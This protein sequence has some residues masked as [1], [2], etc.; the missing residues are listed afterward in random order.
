MALKI[1]KENFKEE[2]LNE[3][4]PVLVDFWAEW[5]S[6]CLMLAPIIDEISEEDNGIKV[7]KINV[8]EEMELALKFS[9]ESIPML[10]LFKD[11]KPIGK[12]VGLQSKDKI[13]KMAG[14]ENGN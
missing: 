2:V 6:P 3:T 4:Q 11:G 10:I 12:T 5:C 8:D 1:T 14:I 13:M 7:G 9:V